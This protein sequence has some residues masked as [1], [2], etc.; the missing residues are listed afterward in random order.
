[1]ANCEERS[2]KWRWLKRRGRRLSWASCWLE[3]KCKVWLN[4][5]TMGLLLLLHFNFWAAA[6]SAAALV[7]TSTFSSSSF[8]V[9]TS[10][11]V[12]LMK[13]RTGAC[14]L[15]AHLLHTEVFTRLIIPKIYDSHYST[16]KTILAMA[17]PLS[18]QELTGPRCKYFFTS[19]AL[20]RGEGK[21]SWKSKCCWHWL[22]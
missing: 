16:S 15:F 7:L 10:L 2:A 5:R 3:R 6:A 4:L 9:V 19:V 18:F 13:R 22:D 17:I 11:V 8:K 21:S 20:P 12:I 1:M 14:C